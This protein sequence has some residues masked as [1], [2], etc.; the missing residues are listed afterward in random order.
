MKIYD[1]IYIFHIEIYFH[2]GLNM[3]YLEMVKVNE[4]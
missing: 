1:K 3:I 2:A 4:Q